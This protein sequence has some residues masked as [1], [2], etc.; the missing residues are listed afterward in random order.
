VLDAVG[1]ALERTGPFDAGLDLCRGTGA[2]VEVLAL[3]L[4]PLA[5]KTSVCSGVLP[6][7]PVPGWPCWT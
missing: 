5:K 6:C 3:S 1:A 2:G 4:S 7:S